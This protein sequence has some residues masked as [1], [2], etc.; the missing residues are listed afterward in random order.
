MKIIFLFLLFVFHQAHSEKVHLLV[1]SKITQPLGNLTV[2][3]A[4]GETGKIVSSKVFPHQIQVINTD[5]TYDDEYFYLHLNKEMFKINTKTKEIQPMK[6]TPPMKQTFSL[7]YN[8]KTDSLMSIGNYNNGFY[9]METDLKTGKTTEHKKIDVPG[10]VPTKLKIA[11]E[12]TNGYYVTSTEFRVQNYVSGELDKVIKYRSFGTF[13][14]LNDET[15]ISVYY[16]TLERRFILQ[17]FDLENNF[18]EKIV[19]YP[20]EFTFNRFSG[21]Q[22]T[23]I[24][25]NLHYCLLTENLTSNFYL[26]ITDIK[27][28]S[29]KSIKLDGMDWLKFYP[30]SIGVSN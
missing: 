18:I 19:T 17:S 22:R 6:V 27:K 26:I 25:G 16:D 24:V 3:T 14:L 8:K 21:F 1:T 30:I 23:R 28:K 29:F 20:A 4:D 7:E 10:L 13:E 5:G 15:A 2:L 11:K 12:K 9:F